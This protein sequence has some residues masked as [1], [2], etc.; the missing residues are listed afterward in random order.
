MLRR[1][2][3]PALALAALVATPGVAQDADPVDPALRAHVTFLADDAMAGRDSFAP[4]YRIAANYVATQLM[5]A[6]VE[7]GGDDDG[8]LQRIRFAATS[9]SERGTMALVRGGRRSELVFGTDFIGT[10]N[11]QDLDFQ[12]SGDVVF[13]GYG[14]VDPDTGWDDFRGLDVKGRI[15]AVLAGG[16]P[17][18]ASEKRAHFSGRIAKSEAAAARGARG[19][20]MIESAAAARSYPFARR[21]ADWQSPSLTWIAPDGKPNLAGGDAP[22]LGMLSRAGAAKLFAGSPVSWSRVEAAEASGAAMPTGALGVR[23]ESR[24]TAQANTLESDN[25]VGMLRGSDPKLAGEHIV[26]VAHLDHVGVEEPDPENPNADRINNGAMDNAIG[27]GML[28]EMARE[29]QKSGKRPRRTVVFVALTA[30]EVGLL[31]SEYYARHPSVPGR[32]VANV[33]LD[34]PVMTWPFE[35]VVAYGAERTTIGATLAAVL[36]EEGLPLTPDPTPE[37]NYF[38]RSDHYSFVKAGI[39]AIYLDPGPAGPGKAAMAAFMDNHYH[40]P[41]DDLTQTFDWRAAQRFM[42]I[43]YRLTRALADADQRPTWRK[44]DFFGEL[45]GGEGAR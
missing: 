39:P 43:H 2:A 4:G 3:A 29:F 32:I 7:P 14:V 9:A 13:A 34:M 17:K 45:F 19:I 18:L 25:V 30:E 21:A 33:N 8:W 26:V 1:F 41:S 44:G 36:K 6:G 10:A 24:Q 40:A 37:E 16:P 31:G 20:V 12:G 5:A 42:R 35:D 11:P 28:I 23:I 22:S 27:V 38:V 15:V